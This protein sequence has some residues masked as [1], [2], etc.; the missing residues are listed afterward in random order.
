MDSEDREFIELTSKMW[1]ESGK[2]DSIDPQDNDLHRKWFEAWRNLERFEIK[3]YK[4][5]DSLNLINIFR[6]LTSHD[7]FNLEDASELH[8]WWCETGDWTTAMKR[9]F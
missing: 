7:P 2:D 9:Y 3:E 5:P 1:N 8:Q 4:D 6:K